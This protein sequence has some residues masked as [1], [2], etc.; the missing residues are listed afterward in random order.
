MAMKYCS[1]M[2]SKGNIGIKDGV[3]VGIGKAG[4]PDTMDITPGLIVGCATEDRGSRGT[5]CQCRFPGQ[6]KFQPA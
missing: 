3:I 2:I 4:N 1:A 5:S 6:R